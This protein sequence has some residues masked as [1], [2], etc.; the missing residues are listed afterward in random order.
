MTKT[1]ESL[2]AIPDWRTALESADN[3]HIISAADIQGAMQA[4]INA[5]RKALNVVREST[6]QECIQICAEQ[7][8]RYRGQTTSTQVIRGAISYVM[9]AMVMLK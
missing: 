6:K 2:A 8:E 9:D 7:I 3:S 4:E 5:L 1:I